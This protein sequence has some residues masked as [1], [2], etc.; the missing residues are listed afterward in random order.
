MSSTIRTPWPSRSAA[1]LDRLPD[2]GQPERLP[3]VDRE[4]GVLALE[5]LEGVEVAG[6]RVARLRTRDVEAGHAA[7]AP[8]DG[9]LGDLHRAGLVTHRGQQLAY[10]DAPAGGRH[11]LL[12]ALLHR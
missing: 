1:P 9:E 10:D 11:P 8:G 2:R 7:V 3:G 12:E 6:G 5:V 4:V